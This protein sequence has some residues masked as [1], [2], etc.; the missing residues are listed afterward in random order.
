MNDG[1]EN[2]QNY[3][4]QLRLTETA[5]ELPNILRKAEQST[6]TYRE[7]IKEIV[8]FELTKR[9]EKSIEKRMRWAKF[10]YMK[11][12]ELFDL[13]DQTSLNERQ[14]NQL[15]E[16][17]WLEQQYNLILLGP[18]GVG[19]T[20]LAIGLGIEAIQKGFNVM[21]VTM[22]EL[23]NLLKTREF[24]RKSQVQLNRIESSDLVIIDDLMYMAMDSREANLFFHLIN[25]L[26]ERSSII[27]TS[28]KSPDQ[29]GELLGDEGITT[30][31]LDRIL[32]RVEVVQMN[33]DSYRMKHR[34]GMF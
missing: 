23:I 28:N 16:L 33:D 10:P 27:L 11:T 1:L 14:L 6:W 31:I 20:H 12:L 21:F 32:H 4:K 15:K 17:N 7:F 34:Q 26:Y 3:F 18:P 2:L 25:H 5:T 24:T 22:G 8:E 9:E 29:W 13:S 19:K 30:A